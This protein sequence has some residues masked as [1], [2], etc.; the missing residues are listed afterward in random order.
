MKEGLFTMK[1]RYIDLHGLAR[2]FILQAWALG[3]NRKLSIGEGS[4]IVARMLGD[5]DAEAGMTMIKR[6]RKK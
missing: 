2:E 3:M 4:E 1:E 5:L 6:S